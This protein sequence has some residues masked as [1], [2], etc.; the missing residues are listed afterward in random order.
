MS[1]GI[2]D[3]SVV[4]T[5]VTVATELATGDLTYQVTFGE[6]VKNT[7]E[8]VSRLPANIR[9]SYLGNKIAI[10]EIVLVIKTEKVP[11]KIGSKWKLRISKDGTLNLEEVK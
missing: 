4:V 11:Y 3:K 9:D 5:S 2:L 6:Y 7:P 1:E 8:I 10:N